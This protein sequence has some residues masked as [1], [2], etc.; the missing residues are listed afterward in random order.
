MIDKVNQ[1]PIISKLTER[2]NRMA[3]EGASP[4]ERSVFVEAIAEEYAKGARAAVEKGQ[5]EMAK[6]LIDKSA[7]YWIIASELN[8]SSA[9]DVPV[10]VKF[11]E[12]GKVSKE[13]AK[14]PILECSEDRKNV[15]DALI[16]L[17]NAVAESYKPIPIAN[18]VRGGRKSFGAPD[19]TKD[20]R[21]KRICEFLS[22][23]SS[24]Y[25]IA[26]IYAE[27]S[28]PEKAVILKEYAD[29]LR[30]AV[31]RRELKLPWEGVIS[32]D[33]MKDQV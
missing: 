5:T 24:K 18:V 8:L 26:S 9:K 2:L 16:L 10:P 21:L 30:L 17:S 1:N 33:T 28:D 13:A 7:D 31:S 27:E 19:E 14:Y 11:L 23:A 20:M 12:A 4:L 22:E 25:D 6:E 3:C 29:R 15:L 32:F